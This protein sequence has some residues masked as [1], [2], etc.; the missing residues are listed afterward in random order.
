MSS[1]VLSTI[2]AKGIR[3]KATFPSKTQE[4]REWYRKAAKGVRYVNRQQLLTDDRN[5]LSKTL[6]PGNMYFFKYDAKYKDVLPYWDEYPLIFPFH[7]EKD[8]FWGINI[9]YLH[10]TLRGKLMDGLYELATNNKY[11]RSMKLRLSYKILKGTT[12]IEM[13]K[14]CIKQ[15]LFS[16]VKSKFMYVYP[17]EW[18]IVAFLPLARFK[19]RTA[20]HVYA[21]SER[22]F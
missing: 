7:V 22:K 11:D 6:A 18:E 4:A 17:S 21:K 10:P 16:H 2:I 19:K 9:H 14:P 1:K 20:N 3:D 5:N 13:F 15:Y 8:R 12:G